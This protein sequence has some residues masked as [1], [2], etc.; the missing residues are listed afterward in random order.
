VPR[1]SQGDQINAHV[2]F[3]EL[4]ISDSGSIENAQAHKSSST[5]LNSVFSVRRFKAVITDLVTFPGEYQ[6]LNF[7][8]FQLNASIVLGQSQMRLQ[9]G[10]VFEP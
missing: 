10:A 8:G 4:F 1:D 6:R 9:K 5:H 7:G 3:W 2:Y